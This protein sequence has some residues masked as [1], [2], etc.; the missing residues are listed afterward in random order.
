MTAQA[1]EIPRIRGHHLI[2]LQFFH[3]KGYS[4]EFVVNLMRILNTLEKVDKL[5]VVDGMDDVC[6]ACPCECVESSCI[7]DHVEDITE[8]D[9]FARDLLGVEVGDTVDY[10]HL[11]N[12]VPHVI[13]AWRERACAGC[14]WETG[15]RSSLEILA[16]LP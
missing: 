1:T 9:A 2:C 10:G 14:E 11:R 5:E 8:L 15:C 4:P 16:R 13:P 6:S 3:G 12:R 7:H